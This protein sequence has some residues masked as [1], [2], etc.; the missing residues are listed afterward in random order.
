MPAALTVSSN[1]D[2]V[3][4]SPSLGGDPESDDG[5]LTPY[6]VM[7]KCLFTPIEH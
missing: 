1:K 4:Q 2:S 6:E 3:V 5:S 7:S